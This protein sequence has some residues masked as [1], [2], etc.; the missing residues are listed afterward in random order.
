MIRAALLFLF[1]TAFPALAAPPVPTDFA[2]KSSLSFPSGRALYELNVP[3]PVYRAAISPVLAD[4]CIFNGRGEVVPFSV[5]NPPQ[6]PLQKR[7]LLPHFHLPDKPVAGEQ[8]TIHVHRSSGKIE[9]V[10]QGKADTTT[11]AYLIDASSVSE[12]IASLELEWRDIPEGFIVRMSVEASDD[13]D[14]WRPVTTTTIASLQRGDSRVEQRQILLSSAKARYLRITQKES[15]STV[16]IT[17]VSAVLSAGSAEPARERL[18]VAVSP[19]PG[20]L[21]EYLFDISGNMPVD[22]I[23]VKL[24]DRNSLVRGIIS[25]RSRESDPWVRRHEGIIYRIDTGE[26]ELSS[27]ELTVPASGDRYW[28]LNISEAGGGVGTA[29]VGV[30][31]AWVPHRIQLLPRGEAPFI[32]AFGSGRVDTRSVRGTDLLSLL[33]AKERDKSKIVRAEAGEVVALGGDVA[34]KK[35]YSAVTRKK[36]LL[37]GVLLLGVA[38]LAWMALRLGRQMKREDE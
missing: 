14:H 25:S 7:T 15:R 37:W 6:P 10:S 27:P 26:D 16:A 28:S 24:P 33:P 2:W 8:L 19:V 11:V 12:P 4:I 3:L 30:E 23:N 18:A 20:K 9:M 17:K 21:G 5:T 13:L 34:L 38:V 1:L 31:V 22:R 32:L 36:I 29:T 35:E